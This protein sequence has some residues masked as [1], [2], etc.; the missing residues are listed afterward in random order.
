[1]IL[2]LLGL[3]I[4]LATSSSLLAA[5]GSGREDEDR[6]ETRSSSNVPQ[7][8]GE[9]AGSVSVTGTG[10]VWLSILMDELAILAQLEIIEMSQAPG[11]KMSIAAVAAP[12]GEFGE[13]SPHLKPLMAQEKRVIE[14]SSEVQATSKIIQMFEDIGI[15]LSEET[16]KSIPYAV[17][18][19]WRSPAECQQFVKG[20]LDGGGSGHM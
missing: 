13:V 14:F 9:I 1:M 15:V 2:L 12:A 20:L 7:P 4:V 10:E 11:Y 3:A 18:C 17:S 6:D 5:N 16:M 8:S 19:G